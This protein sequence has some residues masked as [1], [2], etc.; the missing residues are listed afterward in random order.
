MM[1]NH[2]CLLFLKNLKN[3]HVSAEEVKGEVVR[4]NEN[5]KGFE[6]GVQFI[7]EESDLEML[8]EVIE[9]LLNKLK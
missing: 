8:D 1:R 3:V 5:K 6:Y 2:I 7:A 4:K 9:D